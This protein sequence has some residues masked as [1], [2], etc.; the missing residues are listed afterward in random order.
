MNIFI[1]VIMLRPSSDDAAYCFRILS[2]LCY[3]FGKMKKKS[4]S[5]LFAL[6]KR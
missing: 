5:R 2:F 3:P 1:N 4:F 6:L